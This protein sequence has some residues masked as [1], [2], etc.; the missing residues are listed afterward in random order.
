M[1]TELLAMAMVGGFFVLLLIG[2]PVGISV[3]ASSFIFGYFGFGATLFNLVPARIFGVVTNYTLLALPLFIFMG[4]I[5]EKSRLAEDLLEVIG[6]A[7]GRLRGGT[8]LAIVLVGV[9]MGASSGMVGATVVT[10]GL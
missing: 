10:A 2:V 6:L 8:A 3:A 5:L 7:M 1:E 9:L 4:V